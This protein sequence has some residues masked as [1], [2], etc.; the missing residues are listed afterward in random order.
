[1]LK[2]SF[3]M[4]P[5]PFVA[6]PKPGTPMVLGALPAATIDQISP[7]N[8]PPFG[9]CQSPQNPAV[10]AATAAA[11]GTPTP[12]PCVPLLVAPWTPPSVT[13][14]SMMLP[15]ATEASKCMCGFG[16]VIEVAVPVAG[17]AQAT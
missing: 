4:A 1:M 15:L 7:V 2:C 14:K 6:T 13:T 3:G 16:G 5:S 9:M 8:V 10:A 11:L 17:P 12:A